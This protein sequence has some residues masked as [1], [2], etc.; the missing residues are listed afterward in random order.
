M[1][2]KTPS[3]NALVSVRVPKELLEEFRNSIERSHYLDLSEAM[4]SVLRKR[5]ME[6]RRPEAF[7]LR[8]LREEISTSIKHNAVKQDERGFIRKL[9]RIK[10]ILEEGE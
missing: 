6:Q 5:W 2:R 1:S 3:S 9:E 8:Q 10:K 4:R 7:E